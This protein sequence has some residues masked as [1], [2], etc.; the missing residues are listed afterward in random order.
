VLATATTTCPQRRVDVQHSLDIGVEQ[1]SVA[2]SVQLQFTVQ[3][4]LQNVETEG[5]RVN[6]T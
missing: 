4:G 2:I 5:C 6:S 1:V 3:S